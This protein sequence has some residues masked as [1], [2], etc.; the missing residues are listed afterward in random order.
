MVKVVR[1]AKKMAAISRKL[2]LQ[3]KQIGLVPTM[4]ALHEGHLSLIRQARSQNNV[5]IVTI[6]VNP[7]QFGPQED[8]KRYPRPVFKDIR[9]AKSAGADIVFNPSVKGLYPEAFQTTLKAGKLSQRWDGASRPGHF[10]GV[11]TVVALLFQL[12]R[13]SRAYFGQKDYQQARIIQQLIKDLFFPIRL[14]IMPTLREQD[15]LAM[16]SRNVYLSVSQRQEALVLHQALLLARSRI[17]ARERRAD[18]LIQAMRE[19]VSRAP[20]SRIDYVTIVDPKT[21]EPVWRLRK[22]VVI[23]LA[24]WIGNTRLIDNLLVDVP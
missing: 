5:V 3:K 21:L 7:L 10:D 15:G 22:R 23:L 1:S 17:L 2:E 18:L 13:P 24:V 20:S 12:T 11:A 8:F 6:F 14:M 16:S 4:G 9:L 19:L